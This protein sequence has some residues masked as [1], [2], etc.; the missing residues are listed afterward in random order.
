MNSTLPK[1]W[2]HPVLVVSRKLNESIVIGDD[3]VVSIVDIRR[4][5]VRLGIQAPMHVPVFRQEIYDAIRGYPPRPWYWPEE[6]SDDEERDFLKA[7]DAN[8]YD[9][10]LLLVYADWL[11]ERGDERCDMIRNRIALRR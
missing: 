3:I 9:F 11:E 2:K 5:K 6:P 7:I 8:P 4:D 1:S 10:D